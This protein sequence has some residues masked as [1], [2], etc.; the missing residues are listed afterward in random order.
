VEAIQSGKFGQ[1]VGI[2]G[3]DIVLTPIKEAIAIPR[4]VDP[5]SHYIKTAEAI[6]TSFGI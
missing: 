2:R 1:L 5:E 3:Q 4:R 6:G